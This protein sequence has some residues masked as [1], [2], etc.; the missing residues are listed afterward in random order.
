MHRNVL[1]RGRWLALLA[2]LV[3][4]TAVGSAQTDIDVKTPIVDKGRLSLIK[5]AV[6]RELRADP[7]YRVVEFGEDYAL[8][9]ESASHIDDDNQVVVTLRTPSF[10]GRG[11]EVARVNLQVTVSPHQLD[12]IRSV[13]SERIRAATIVESRRF[14]RGQ[15]LEIVTLIVPKGKLVATVAARAILNAT[16]PEPRL[17]DVYRSSLVGNA[18][19]RVLGEMTSAE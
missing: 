6:I 13:S 4:T 15:F 16:I 12:S 3:V 17:N 19:V 2:G 7:R 5:D 11:E 8:W 9:I 10:I 1:T 14:L 18:I